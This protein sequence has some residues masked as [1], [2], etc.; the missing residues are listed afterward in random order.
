MRKLLALCFYTLICVNLIAQT[1]IDSTSQVVERPKIG[2]VMSGG[3]AK[4]FAHIGALKV[5]EEAGLPI[6]F[7]A[8]TSMGSIIAGLYAIGYDPD[9]I[10]KLVK[11]QDWPTVINDE[12][13]RKYIPIED[14]VRQ[15]YYT[16]TFSVDK[17][18][19][20]IK[21]SLRDG[22][23]INLLLTRIM[24]PSK[25]ESDFS[26]FEVPFLCI[27]SDLE[28]CQPYEITKGDLAHA[29]RASMSIP[30]F[31][32]PVEYD[33]RLCVDGGMCNNFPVKNVLAKG[34]YFIIG[35]DV[36][37]DFYK[38]D[39]LDNSMAMADQMLTMLG[40]ELNEENKKYIDLYISPNVKDMS[41]MD[42]TSFDSIISAGERAAREKLPELKRIYDSL[43]PTHP[44]IKERPHVMPLDSV[45]ITKL[46][47]DTVGDKSFKIIQR[48][49]K[50]DLPAMMAIDEIEDIMLRI[51]ATG[52]YHDVWYELRPY[53]TGYSL[54][55]HY[56][57]VSNASVSLSAHY[58]T[59][60]GI[61]ILLN[62]SMRNLL[63]VQR[64]TLFETDLNIAENP[65]ANVRYSFSPLNKLR[66]GAEFNAFYLAF[67][68]YNNSTIMNSYSVQSNKLDI[69][70][71]YFPSYYHQFRFGMNNGLM[72]FKDKLDY[73]ISSD[74]YNFYTYFYGHY[75][76]DRQDTYYFASQGI[77]MNLLFKYIMPHEKNLEGAERTNSMTLQFDLEESIRIWKRHSLKIGGTLASKIGETELPKYMEFY[78]GGQSHM[79]YSDNIVSFDGLRFTQKNVDHLAFVKMAWQYNFYKMF[80]AIASA[81]MG[82][83]A[84][85]YDSWIDPDSFIAGCG[86]TAGCKTLIGPLELK[87]MY[88]N[89]SGSGLI[90]FFNFGFWF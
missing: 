35:I 5:I 12:I 79:L 86:L 49:F 85:N 56:K 71:Q 90:G 87:L 63:G 25:G 41:I 28:T 82:Y 32:A 59:D 19:L 67:D 10:A 9:S 52:Y 77:K 4:G 14:K 83:M 46:C 18:G 57:L 16:A 40:M 20:K 42:F 1:D 7:V 36:Q 26:K 6:D 31:F 2:V 54:N 13:P 29:I 62:F 43:Y 73:Q 60:Y 75:F 69:F 80:Y 33:G 34:D 39:Q 21:P 38:K 27:A 45:Y 11:A 50:R 89:I 22:E 24:T 68:H 8:G 61:G 65:F 58:D 23:R 47:I 64:R 70:F 74:S 66:I 51:Y 84:D 76:F 53:E 44:Q 17:N 37:K 78:V 55:I 15:R 3:G 88:S 30:F 48:L 72:H 81:N